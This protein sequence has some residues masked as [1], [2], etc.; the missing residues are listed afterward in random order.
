VQVNGKLR[1]TVELPKDVTQ[2]RAVEEA[3]KLGTV[4]KFVGEKNIAKVVFVPGRILNLILG[5]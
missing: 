3:L 2:E 4:T 1:G 5:K